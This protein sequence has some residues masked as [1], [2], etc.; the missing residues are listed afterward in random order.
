TGGA[1]AVD[2][3]VLFVHLD[4]DVLGLGQDG[5]GHRRGV[6]AA[7]G[8]GLGHPLH[9]V[10]SPFV[11]EPAVGAAPLDDGRDL[12]DAADPGLREVDDLDAPPLLLGVAAVHAEELGREEAGLVAAGAGAD[13]ED[14]VAAVV[15]V[16][17]RQL[18][19][20]LLF[21]PTNALGE[22]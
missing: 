7:G 9:A 11:L 2:A 19:P 3:Q 5:D 16:L 20:E 22:L 21:Q 13:L 15:R 8:L 10:D 6:D 14:D 18:A 17:G 4:L 1:E 12:L